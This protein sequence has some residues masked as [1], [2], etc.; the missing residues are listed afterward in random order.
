[1]QIDFYYW[2][3]QCPINYETIKLLNSLDSNLFEISFYDIT[4][5][6]A[7][8]PNGNLKWFQNNGYKDEGL[9]SIEEDYAKLHVVSKNL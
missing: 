7:V 9:V 2:G 4:D 6:K 1:M 5:D 3:T 8:F